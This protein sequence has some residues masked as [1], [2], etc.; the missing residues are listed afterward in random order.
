MRARARS[1]VEL[2]D[3]EDIEADDDEEND[4]DDYR[5]PTAS[6]RTAHMM[7]PAGPGASSSS[8]HSFPEKPHDGLYD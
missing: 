5:G 8:Y 7:P 2:V 1:N 6:E 3:D 4:D